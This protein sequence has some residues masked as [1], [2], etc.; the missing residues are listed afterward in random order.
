MSV[1]LSIC[2]ATYGHEKYISKALNSILSQKVDFEYEIL[3]GEDCSPD[4]SRIILK[5]YEEKFPNIF[6]VIYRD[7][8]VGAK[9]NFNELYRLARGKYVIV[10][11]LDDFWIDTKKLQKQ[12]DYLETHN[13][14]FAVSHRS[15]IIDENG[16][17]I[18]KTYPECHSFYYDI[19]LLL[20]GILPGQTTTIMYRNYHNKPCFS[21]D[22][23]NSSTVGPGDKRKVFSMCSYGKIV[24]FSE[25]MSCYRMVINSGYSFSARYKGKRAIDYSYWNDFV[26]YSKQYVTDVH[27]EKISEALML[28]T[29]FIMK[30]NREIS[31]SKLLSIYLKLNYK[32][33]SVYT[34]FR[35]F[36]KVFICRISRNDMQFKKISKKDLKKYQKAYKQ[37]KEISGNIPL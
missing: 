21:L 29:A 12:V 26:E 25:F 27:F 14:V 36:L 15:I 19:S 4:N 32:M 37:S 34:L 24:C 6:H 18:L 17:L 33:Y 28:R 20:D 1:K 10:L 9:N 2:C 31:L 8:N 7:K 16:D 5:Q 23:I 11:E 3:I 35:Y 13:D 22:L 30:K